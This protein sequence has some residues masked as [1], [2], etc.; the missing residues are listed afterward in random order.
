[1]GFGGWSG[2]SHVKAAHTMS[3]S[4]LLDLRVLSSSCATIRA[5]VR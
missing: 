2:A 5:K 3:P 4:A 1:M